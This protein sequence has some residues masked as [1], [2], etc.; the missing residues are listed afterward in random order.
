MRCQ[1]QDISA[2]EA[3]A[4]REASRAAPPPTPTRREQRPEI[5]TVSLSR[6]KVRR[7]D[8]LPSCTCPGFRRG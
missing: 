4:A 8:V 6:R 7:C 1:Q 3:A 2:A 5:T